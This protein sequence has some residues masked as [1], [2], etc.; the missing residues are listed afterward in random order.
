MHFMP[1]NNLA[2]NISHFI[3]N[4]PTKKFLASKNCIS[5]SWN[6]KIAFGEQ[7]SRFPKVFLPCPQ[8]IRT[9]EPWGKLQTLKK[10]ITQVLALGLN[11]RS[12]NLSEM[13]RRLPVLDFVGW[14]HIAPK[15]LG[16]VSHGANLKLWKKILLKF[17]H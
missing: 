16:Q 9:S 11:F 2:E 1:N 14:V 8:V 7:G 10:I 5:N 4:A 13:D 15:S 17:G 3:L 6:S 12:K